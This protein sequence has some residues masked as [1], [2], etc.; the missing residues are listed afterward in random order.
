MPSKSAL[1]AVKIYFEKLEKDLPHH[2]VVRGKV[3]EV[4]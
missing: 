4:I 3:K 1:S 2:I